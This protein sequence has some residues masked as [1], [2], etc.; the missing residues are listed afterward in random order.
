MDYHEQPEPLVLWCPAAPASASF[1]AAAESDRRQL[2]ACMAFRDEITYS[3]LSPHTH[4][5]RDTE[6]AHH[7]TGV[8]APQ[9]MRKKKGL[10]IGRKKGVKKW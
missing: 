8:G 5:R 9:L 4:A 3:Y 6:K 1:F 7:Y 2:H 10:K